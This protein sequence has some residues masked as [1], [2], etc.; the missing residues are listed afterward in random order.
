MLDAEMG[1]TGANSF[2]TLA[3][4]EGYFATRVGAEAWTGATAAVRTQALLLA[5]R[6]LEQLRWHGTR[7]S[8][9][10]ALSW[11]RTGVPGATDGA[12]PA[13]IKAA[14]CEEALAW[15]SPTL[16]RRRAL[17]AAGVTDAQVAGAREAY[18]PADP[19][20]LLSAEARALLTGW[21]R[22]GGCLVTDAGGAR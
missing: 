3:E 10:Q 16:V 6:A 20:A 15:L 9:S 2:V 7:A 5:A 14:Q 4:A 13:V 18:A 12:I 1:G 8:A 21:V 17:Q 11:P 19:T 22:L